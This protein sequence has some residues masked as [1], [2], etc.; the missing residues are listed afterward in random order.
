MLVDLKDR[1]YQIQIGSNLLESLGQKIAG[2]TSAKK[3]AIVTDDRVGPIYAERV[4][5]SLHSANIQPFLL[6]VSAGEKSKSLS[7]AEVLLDKM[8]QA[9]L[10]RGSFV[11]ALGELLATLQGL[12]LRFISGVFL[13]S[14][15]PQL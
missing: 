13:T 14:R 1:S 12:S 6:T 15:F 8:T 5:E 7:T 9:G 11:I 10:D 2:L 3:C 4:L